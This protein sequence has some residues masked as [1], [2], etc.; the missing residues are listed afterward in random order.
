M[1]ACRC[2]VC[3]EDARVCAHVCGDRVYVFKPNE[4]SSRYI[5]RFPTGRLE[6]RDFAG[7]IFARLLALEK[8]YAKKIALS[9][10]ILS[11][12]SRDPFDFASTRSSGNVFMESDR[13]WQNFSDKTS[14]L[15]LSLLS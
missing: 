3:G 7:T 4:L 6:I 14:S 15:S 11:G 2:D 5:S 1:R 8:H 10:A 13:T 9:R 12:I